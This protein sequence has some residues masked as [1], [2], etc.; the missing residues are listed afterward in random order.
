[1][2]YAPLGLQRT[3]GN[4]IFNHYAILFYSMDINL[5]LFIFTDCLLNHEK[6]GIYIFCS[7]LL[8]FENHTTEHPGYSFI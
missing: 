3:D 7:Q 8:G 1:M 5:L 2:P 6:V 4:D